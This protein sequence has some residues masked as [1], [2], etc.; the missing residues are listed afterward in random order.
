M[1]RKG[2]GY[3]NELSAKE[4]S[5]V[6]G[7][8]ES[9]MTN[10]TCKRTQE[11]QRHYAYIIIHHL[12]E[13]KVSLD[14]AQGADFA[15]AAARIGQISKSQNSRQ[16]ILS[17]LKSMARFINKRRPIKDADSVLVDVIAGSPSKQNKDVLMLSE[18]ERVLNLPMKAKE[19]AYL[20]MLYDGYLRPYEPFI[21]KW[22]D[23]KI[24]ADNHIEYITDFKTG[25]PRTIVMKPDA[26]AILEIWRRECGRNYGDDVYVFPNNDGNQY[27]TK[28]TATK[29]FQR[30]RKAT[31]YKKL[32]PSSIRNTAISHDVQ[33]ELP[34]QYVCMRAWGEPYNEMIN[35]YVKANSS[36]LQ[37]STQEKN[38]RVV[39]DLGKDTPRKIKTLQVCPKCGK[40]NVVGG[41][42]CAFCGKSFI[43]ES[44]VERENAELKARLAA[45]DAAQ[46]ASSEKV[47]SLVEYMRKNI[48]PGAEKYVPSEVS[49]LSLDDLMS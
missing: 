49:D 16:S 7:F 31:G 3:Q 13:N 40:Q 29:L 27:K 12:H 23:L 32:I 8:V 14:K 5:I 28:E 25:I 36:K 47:D 39:V 34:L 33:A 44:V 1:P 15:R 20:A 26:V 2:S 48:K 18:W 21:L 4:C 9:R 35:I 42:F 46:K 30:L 38:G 6:E 45:I 17:Q 43:G 41:E 19:R 11:K 24:G 37:I 10:G 22:S